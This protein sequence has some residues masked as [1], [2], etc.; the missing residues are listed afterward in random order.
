VLLHLHSAAHGGRQPSPAG[1]GRGMVHNGG[2]ECQ[3]GGRSR[4]RWIRQCGA[5][6]CPVLCA[7]WQALYCASLFV[8]AVAPVALQGSH[9]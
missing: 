7:P 9:R 6:C 3:H 4:V 1:K 5:C 2:E 8:Q